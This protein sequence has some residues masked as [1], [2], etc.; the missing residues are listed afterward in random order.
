VAVLWRRRAEVWGVARSMLS[1]KSFDE[2]VR[3]N[4]ASRHPGSAK[5]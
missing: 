3:M 5:L 4:L 1:F 2:K